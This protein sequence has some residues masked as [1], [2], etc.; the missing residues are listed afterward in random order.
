MMGKW[1]RFP[2]DW[3]EDKVIKGFEA[4]VGLVLGLAIAKGIPWLIAFCRAVFEAL[5]G[6]TRW[7]IRKAEEVTGIP[8]TQ[9]P[10]LTALSAGLVWAFVILPGGVVLLITLGTSVWVLTLALNAPQKT[11]WTLLF[12]AA[13]GFLVGLILSVT[14][15]QMGFS[16]PEG[17]SGVRLDFDGVGLFGGPGFSGGWGSI[18]DDSLVLGQELDI[19]D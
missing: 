11:L 16:G 19:W 8:I 17:D 10:F 13:V 12:F 14:D 5:F 9:S 7:L 2:G 6:F 3:I 1:P 18:F 4:L 15:P